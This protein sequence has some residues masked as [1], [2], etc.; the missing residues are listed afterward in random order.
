MR[1]K[2]RQKKMR[3]WL[4]YLFFGLFAAMGTMFFVIATVLPLW[5]IYSAKSWIDVPCRILSS[6]VGE[7]Q[8]EDGPT[9]RVDITYSYEFGGQ[10]YTGD[11][12]D[13]SSGSSSGYEGK[14][15]IVE[16]YP[17]GLDTECYADPDKPERSVINR[18][19]GAYLWWGLMSLPFM[20]IGFGGL[21]WLRSPARLRKPEEDDDEPTARYATSSTRYSS[22][23]ASSRSFSPGSF[24][25]G[26]ADQVAGTL[27]P[28]HSRRAK[29]LFILLFAVVWNA[30]V[31]FLLV[32]EVLPGLRDGDLDWM[33]GCFAIPFALVG[34]GL[35]GGVIY[36]LLALFNPVIEI[37]IGDTHLTPGE[38]CT[39]R[40]S[41]TGNTRRIRHLTFTFEGREAATY[42]RGTDSVTDHHTFFSDE[43]VSTDH[44]ATLGRGSATLTVPERTMPS[45]E[46]SNNKIGWRLTVHGDIPYWPDV[47]EDFPIQVYPTEETST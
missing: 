3:G 17:V 32:S 27:K 13:F 38:S 19:P 46:S 44:P 9:Y 14:A 15:R 21:F 24:S 43:I 23:P 40:W 39:V 8:G 41:F 7:S 22:T 29:L 47:N 11:R 10:S 6:E 31:A 1:S 20:I 5:Q 4:A 18:A 42:R 33:T 35:I 2:V 34:V 16:R 26:S 37:E 45:F 36:M 30:I 28:K 12:Y 25:Y